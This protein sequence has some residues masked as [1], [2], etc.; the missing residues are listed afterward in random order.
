MFKILSIGIDVLSGIVVILPILLLLNKLFFHS[1]EKTICY[2]IFSMYLSAVLS[3]V[4]FPSIIDFHID[5]TLNIIPFIDMVSD[6]KNAILNVVLFIPL[7]I[8]LPFI[9][10]NFRKLRNTLIF[11]FG[12]TIII[13]CFQIFTYRTTD[14]NDIITN[15]MGTIIGW[16]IVD[17]II[18][19][20]PQIYKPYKKS[21][22]I[23]L[24][25]GIT[26]FVMC[27][28]QPLIVSSVWDIIL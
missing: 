21:V 6:F 14:I 8:M 9:W 16:L 25:S 18:K 15:I 17:V 12:L 27:F 22:E 20:F 4:G 7:G 13:E 5:L 1:W 2:I 23:I 10:E 26:F 19:R 3:S 24:L 11:G 28:V